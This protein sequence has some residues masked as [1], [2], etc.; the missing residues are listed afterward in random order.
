[1][2]RLTY[3]P[4]GWDHAVWSVNGRVVLRVPKRE[5]I[6][7][8]DAAERNLLAAI[9][10][11]LPLAVPR[12][13]RTFEPCELAPFGAMLTTFVPGRPLPPQLP[14]QSTAPEEIGRFLAALHSIPVEVGEAAGLRERLRTWAER[15]GFAE[16]ERDV[17]PLVTPLARAWLTGLYEHLHTVEHSRPAG[18]TILHGDF[19]HDHIFTRSPT[20]P[21]T[22][23]IDF[24]DTC[25]GDPAADW[26]GLW[27][28]GRGVVQR[29][30]TAAKMT[31]DS[32][33][34][35]AWLTRHTLP[36]DHI[37]FGQSFGQRPHGLE[38]V[39]RSVAEL[40]RDA[41]AA[42]ASMRERRG[43]SM[44]EDPAQAVAQLWRATQGE[45]VFLGAYLRG[46]RFDEEEHAS[47]AE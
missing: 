10:D 20:G 36:A 34:E 40:N 24:G 42:S 47:A 2:R 14:S 6:A 45:L 1:M 37:R 38:L 33:L 25:I 21:L 43:L 35:R 13:L 44:L 3:K 29:V 28:W 27:V 32:V 30:A 4:G 5:P 46:I 9:G 41:L 18:A 23:V 12:P 17:F 19:T 8:A 39:R 11:R 15:H 16:V 7:A 31:D 26:R 22:G